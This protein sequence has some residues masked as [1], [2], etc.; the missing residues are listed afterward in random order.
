MLGA[1]ATGRTRIQGLLEAEDVLNTARIV[2]QL[3]AKATKTAAGWEV[4]GRGTGG[5]VQPAGPLDFGNAGT[6]ARL[7]M[8]VLAGHDITAEMIGDASLSRRPMG[9]VLTPLKLMGVTVV[10]ADRDRLPLQ[11]RGTSRLADRTAAGIFCP[12]EVGDPD[13]R[14]QAPG[15]PLRSAGGDADHTEAC[16]AAGATLRRTM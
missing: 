6:G 9:R 4:M 10:P 13:R 11:F 3:G 2:G 14:Q 15:R 7:M 8:G 12:S 1:L 16:S 5:L